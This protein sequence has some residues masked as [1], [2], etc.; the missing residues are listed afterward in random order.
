MGPG[1][2]PRVTGSGCLD[3]VITDGRRRAQAFFNVAG[4]EKLALKMSMMRP[5]TGK[6]ISLKLHLDREFVG[7]RLAGS[8][9][10]ALDLVRNTEDILDMV[11]DF[12]SDDVGLGEIPGAPNRRSSSLKE[13]RSR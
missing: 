13:P 8:S 5:H 12:V 2:G 10:L 4:L 11:A 3:G 1:L 9:A 7:Q 6:A